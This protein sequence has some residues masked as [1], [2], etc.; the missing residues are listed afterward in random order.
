MTR[1][2]LKRLGLSRIAFIAGVGLP[3]I[4]AT[5]ARAQAP[6]A[7]AP[8]GAQAEAERVIVTGSNIP[9]AEEVGPN[10]VL[11]LNRDLINKSGERS[12]EQL[13]RDQPVANANSVQVQNNGTSQS[14][15][16][17]GT[18]SVSLRGFDPSA[19]LV[20]IDGRR[21]TAFPG[22]GFFDLNTIPLPAIESIEILK[23]GASATYGADA[24]AGVVNFKLYKDYRGAQ[25]TLDYGDTL[26]KDAGLYSGDILF[27]TGDDKVSINGDIFFFHHNSTFNIDRGNSLKPPF[28]SSNAIPFNLQVSRATVLPLLGLHPDP[29]ANL[30]PVNNPGFFTTVPDPNTPGQTLTILNAAG[31]ALVGHPT[32]PA[33]PMFQNRNDATNL[34]KIPGVR[35]L[36][37]L[38]GQAGAPTAVGPFVG[39]VP[40]NLF[41][42]TPPTKTNGLLPAT[43]YIYA[44]GRVRSP[45]SVLPGFN[46]NLQSSSYPEQERWGGYAAFNDKLCDDQVQLYGDFYYDDV[47]T[48]DELAP[49]ATGS[50]ET[51]GQ[52]TLFIPPK[53]AFAIDPVTG[54]QI[55]PPNTPT[56]KEVGMPTGAF[57][58]FNPFQQII[59]AGTRARLFD[60]GN[61]F[62]DEE[63][64]AWL[65]T[66]GVKGDKLFDGNWGYDAGFRYSQILQVGQVR[67]TSV[68]RFD[69]IVN[70]NDPL[71][72]PNS[73]Q[74]IGTTVPFNPFGNKG[75]PFDQKLIDFARLNEKNLTEN[76]LTE[77]NLNIYTTDLFDM[78]AGPVGLAFGG[79]WRRENF[80][81]NPD[82]QARLG[83]EVGVAVAPPS[84]GGRKDYA[85]YTEAQIP[86]F[87]PEMGIWGLHNVEFTASARYEA[88]RNNDTDVLVPKVSLR[89]QPFDEQLTIRSTWG[90]GFLEPSLLEFFGGNLFTLAPTVLNGHPE[91]ETTTEITA[92]R[93]LHPER[94]RNWSG[95]AVYTPKWFQ[96]LIPNT[97]LTI[98][99]DLW[100]IERKGVVIVPSDQ[101]VVSRFVKGTLLPGE[102]VDVD[103]AT[104]SVNFVKTTFANSGKENANGAD[105]GFQ[106]QFQTANWGT[107]TWLTETTYL[108]S[109]VFQATDSRFAHEVSGRSVSDPWDS[110]ALFG[111]ATIGDGWLKWKGL[112]RIDWA[113]RNFDLNWTVH[114][115]DGYHEEI[116]PNS[117][118]MSPLYFLDHGFLAHSSDHYVHGTWFFDCQASYTIVFTPPVESA[119][120]AGYSKGGKEVMTN[121]EGKEIESTAAYSMPCWKTLLNNTT[122]TVGCNDV[123]GQDPPPSRGFEAGNANNYPGATY[124]NLG[125]FVY[126]EIK[127]KF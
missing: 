126:G 15:G 40:N 122:L 95:G 99:V 7:P 123:F 31:L 80:E 97:T 9:T 111:N 11:N 68:T 44:N 5:S 42:T 25:V 62:F 101:E 35:K 27:G 36:N 102:E 58:P 54:L 64:E 74:F 23:D 117:V 79:E 105:L 72:D 67:D 88:F 109:F 90:E 38:G 60:W 46:F 76:K 110:A 82:D 81:F 75:T 55:S 45:F 51:K 14:A 19:T 66:L 43:D 12:T 112:S 100:D 119:P 70:G 39:F 16:P 108:N 107:F 17:V 59:S 32:N 47:K 120:V 116:Q 6:A 121:K 26:D 113:W 115:L 118:T 114:Y 20:L 34:A 92:N 56:A 1:N 125:R 89:W 21:V 103:P 29:I 52:G 94:S 57:N 41:F 85:F 53:T 13:L 84:R 18:S 127:K 3:L 33:D 98:H 22:T 104:G 93:N 87:S 106:L 37:G 49:G 96:N 10:P 86:L 4:I 63:N 71:F 48:H 77:L 30:N 24:V 61:R 8:A 91:P 65:A 73:S 83:D 2:V 124:D 78:P 28:L 50:F 69:R